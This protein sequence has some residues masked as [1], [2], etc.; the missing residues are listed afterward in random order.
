MAPGATKQPGIWDSWEERDGAWL[1][2]GSTQGRGA[3]ARSLGQALGPEL[4]REGRRRVPVFCQNMETHKGSRRQRSAGLGPGSSACL[5]P[6]LALPPPPL[7]L[8]R[9]RGTVASHEQRAIWK[10]DAHALQPAGALAPVRA[11]PE[12]PGGRCWKPTSS[13]KLGGPGVGVG[14][15]SGARGRSGPHSP[16]R[17]LETNISV[18]RGRPCR[19]QRPEPRTC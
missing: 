3:D 11:V 1:W 16:V 10:L 14:G 13:G 17:A 19:K 7:P 5:Q 6:P 15:D 8:P 12:F 18:P 9:P 2:W 4:P